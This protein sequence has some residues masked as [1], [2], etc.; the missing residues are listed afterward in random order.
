MDEKYFHLVAAEVS[1]RTTPKDGEEVQIGAQRINVV[2]ASDDGQVPGRQLDRA[3]QQ[4]QIKFLELAQDPTLQ[5][6]DVFIIGISFLGQMTQEEFFKT[7]DQVTAEQAAATKQVRP[8][9][10]IVKTDSVIPPGATDPFA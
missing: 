6:F 9:L 2:L 1:F 5:V 4:A 3:Q 10:S 8:V 7:Q